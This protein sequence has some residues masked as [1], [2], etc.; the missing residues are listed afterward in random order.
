MTFR[1]LA[2]TLFPIAFPYAPQ[3]QAYAKCTQ[4]WLCWGLGLE[5]LAW[6]LGIVTSRASGVFKGAVFLSKWRSQTIGSVFERAKGIVQLTA[7]P[8]RCGIH[9]GRIRANVLD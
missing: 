5:F 3:G 4:V 2:R 8:T 6:G 9:N 7:F 1:P